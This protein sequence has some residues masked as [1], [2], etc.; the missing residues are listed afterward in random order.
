MNYN[1]KT[2]TNL[3]NSGEIQGDTAAALRAAAI[4][5][6]NN[7]SGARSNRRAAMASAAR[8]PLAS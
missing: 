6:L 4:T 7:N 1:G 8:A 3:N 2:I 5:L